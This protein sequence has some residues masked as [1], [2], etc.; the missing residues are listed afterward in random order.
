M[1]RYLAAVAAL[2]TLVAASAAAPPTAVAASTGMAWDSVMKFSLEGDASS[3]QPGSFDSDYAAASAVQMPDQGG[4]GGIFGQINKAKATA[5][6]TQQMMKTGSAQR[7]YIAGSKERSD[8]LFFQTATIT[9]CSARTI[10]T[11][12]LRRKTYKVESMD[13]PSSGSGSSGGGSGGSKFS[14]DGSRIALMVTNTALG[15]R[16]VGGLPTNGYRSDMTITTTKTS[17]ESQTEHGNMV[18]YYSNDTSPGLNCWGGAGSGAAMGAAGMAMMGK[19]SLIM[20][21][22]AA[23]GLSSRFS[24]TQSGPPLP[25]GKLAMFDA[26][27]FNAQGHSVTVS[28]ENGNVRSIA[29]N[30]SAFSIPADFTQQQ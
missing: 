28:T 8:N 23:H 15:A 21:A 20:R 29:A 10:T 9:D 12:D 7:H 22:I 25:A 3:Q 1:H 17:G 30:D 16:N 4:G 18:A 27:T 24:F 14:D 11:L 6:A 26:M 5:E 2:A 19:Y 13:S